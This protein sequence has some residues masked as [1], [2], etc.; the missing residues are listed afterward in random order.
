M[1][2]NRIVPIGIAL[3]IVPGT[4]LAWAGFST[5]INVP[6]DPAPAFVSSNTQLNVGIAGTIAD[7][8]EAGAPDAENRDIEININGGIVGT[9]FNVNAGS[10]ANILAGKVG[11]PDYRGPGFPEPTRIHAGGVLNVYGGD[12][13]PLQTQG[14]GTLNILGGRVGILSHS[15]P[16]ANVVFSGG[17]VGWR[18]GIGENGALTVL[19]DEFRINGE[20]VSGL[21][22]VGDSREIEYDSSSVY[23]G[24]L[25]DGT[26]FALARDDGDYIDGAFILQKSTVAP[27]GEH[28]IDASMDAVPYGI[29]NGQVLNVANGAEVGDS[30]NAGRNSTLNVGEGGTVG[31]N[32][33]AI[34]AEINLDGGQ[35]MG[36]AGGI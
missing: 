7:N 21:V 32:M 15:S 31:T 14:G 9:G 17:T 16:G 6:P 22:R 20:P 23:T 19:G 33:E 36:R 29:R 11:A 25:A 8:F 26:P 2:N 18:F 5:V 30:F 24:V 10:V 35:I 28:L 4:R 13:G 27:V 34:G 1:P 3:F 12:T